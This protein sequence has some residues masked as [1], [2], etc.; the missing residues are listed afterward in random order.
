[1]ILSGNISK[2]RIKQALFRIYYCTYCPNNNTYGFKLDLF[3]LYDFYLLLCFYVDDIYRVLINNV[4]FLKFDI[5]YVHNYFYDFY[6]LYDFYDFYF[7]FYI[8]LFLHIYQP[9]QGSD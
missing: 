3:G 7:S 4:K 9:D 8:N 2:Y 1:M 6:G 5:N